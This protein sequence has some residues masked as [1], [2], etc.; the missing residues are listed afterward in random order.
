M[1][2]IHQKLSVMSL[3]AGCIKDKIDHKDSKV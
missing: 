2:N 1:L 3:C